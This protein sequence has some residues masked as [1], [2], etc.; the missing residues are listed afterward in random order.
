M[1][2]ADEPTNALELDKPAAGG[3]FPETMTN[4]PRLSQFGY[5]SKIPLTP[6]KK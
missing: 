5:S 1:A 6:H 2:S 4:I 3:I